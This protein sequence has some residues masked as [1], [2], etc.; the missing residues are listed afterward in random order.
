MKV[1]QF[2]PYG[3]QAKPLPKKSTS[4]IIGQIAGWC[5][6][7]GIVLMVIYWFVKLFNPV[8]QPW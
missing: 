3:E 8:A 5:M 4:Y 1:K 6:I 7:I 2:S